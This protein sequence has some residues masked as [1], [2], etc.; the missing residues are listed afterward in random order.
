MVQSLQ[1][2]YFSAEWKGH[3][4]DFGPNTSFSGLNTG[5]ELSYVVS[6]FIFME[7]LCFFLYK[8]LKVVFSSLQLPLNR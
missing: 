7:Y 1:L 5:I 4:K 3:S 8:I 6:I 2:K